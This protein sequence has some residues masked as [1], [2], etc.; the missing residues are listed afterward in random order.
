MPN[1]NWQSNGGI[2]RS[3]PA[4]ARNEPLARGAGRWISVARPIEAQ[5]EYVRQA[6]AAYAG[7]RAEGAAA[8]AI[9]AEL[10]D[11]LLGEKS[12]DHC[13]IDERIMV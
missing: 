7:C 4:G 11:M 10:V 1:P 8:E 12:D 9:R 2:P 3:S 5:R 13:S 6:A